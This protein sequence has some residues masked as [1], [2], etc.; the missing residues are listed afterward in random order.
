M[1]PTW[2]DLVCARCGGTVGAGRC[3]TCRAARQ[4]FLDREPTVPSP[5]QWALFLAALVLAV[6]L[7]IVHGA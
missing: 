6:A 2:R 7:Y 3:A 1:E 4:D 5:A